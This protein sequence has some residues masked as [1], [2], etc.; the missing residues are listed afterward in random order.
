MRLRGILGL[1][2]LSLLFWGPVSG[3]E[4]AKA[5]DRSGRETYRIGIED[6]L[7]IFV[8]GEPDLSGSFR[9]LP[10]GSISLPLAN[11]IAVQGLT[12]VEVRNVVRDA[13]GKFINDP[14]VTVIVET[15]NSYRVY[16]LGEVA[17]QG[18]L[19]FYRPTRLMQAIAAAGGLTEFAK[20]EITLVRDRGG[21]EKRFRI[22]YKRLIN[23]DPGQENIYL[24]PGDT[25]IF[26]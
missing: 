19:Q 8:W 13:L 24:E 9:V 6:E 1:L 26:H 16:F 2:A 25:L 17:R 15:I 20:K 3:Q 22:D 11:D 12:T 23:G 18:A 7:R 10:D 5:E 14:N 4:P 21:V